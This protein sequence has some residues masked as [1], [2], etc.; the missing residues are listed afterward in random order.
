MVV[1]PRASQSLLIVVIQLVQS[2][3][4]GRFAS[5]C[6]TVFHPASS[7]LFSQARRHGPL[8]KEY[9][10][11]TLDNRLNLGAVARS[12]VLHGLVR[13]SGRGLWKPSRLRHNFLPIVPGAGTPAWNAVHIRH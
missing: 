9:T 6:H 1:A 3:V 10:T 12:A 2:N 11:P 8:G 4:M 7:G 5:Q 13:T